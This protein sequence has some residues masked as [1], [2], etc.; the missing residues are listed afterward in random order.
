MPSG[1]DLE[2]ESDYDGAVTNSIVLEC[3]DQSTPIIK[4]LL[5]PRST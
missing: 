5:T 3:L 4:G 2:G 1:T